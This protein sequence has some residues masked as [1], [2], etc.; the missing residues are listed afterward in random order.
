[1]RGEGDLVVPDLV[2]EPEHGDEEDGGEGVLEDLDQGEHED[3][4]PGG[5]T[6]A[7]SKDLRGGR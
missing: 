3:Y 1:M 4:P 6:A 7:L 5:G 2:E